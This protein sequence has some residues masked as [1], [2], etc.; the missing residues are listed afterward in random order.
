MSRKATA[1]SDVA[2]TSAGMSPAAILQKRQS[3]LSVLV[4]SRRLPGAARG[5]LAQPDG[6]AET[7]LRQVFPDCY[8]PG[9]AR[10]KAMWESLRRSMEIGAPHHRLTAPPAQVSSSPLTPH[11]LQSPGGSRGLV[12]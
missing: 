10:V 8:V 2:T 1:V 7:G 11:T 6:P 5:R 9:N 12:H 4:M 3:G